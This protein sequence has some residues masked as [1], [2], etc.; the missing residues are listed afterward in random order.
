MITNEK[1]FEEDIELFLISNE[2]GYTKPTE[3]YDVDLGFYVNTLISFVKTT[4]P[5]EWERFE[6]TC[7]SDPIKKFCVALDN[8]IDMDGLVS[9]LRKGFKHRGITFRVCYF[10]PESH[11]NKTATALY[12]Q[13]ICYCQFLYKLWQFRHTHSSLRRSLEWCYT[14]IHSQICY[15]IRWNIRC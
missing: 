8:A 5:K 7:N 9:V 11:L 10:K 2:G 13:N 1:R 6:K 12:E 15:S 4:Q 3:K 14:Y